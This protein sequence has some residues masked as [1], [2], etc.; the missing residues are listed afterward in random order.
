MS[1]SRDKT[2]VALYRNIHRMNRQ[3]AI[4]KTC[5]VHNL[6]DFYLVAF[7]Y[8]TDGYF[9]DVGAYDGIK[10]SNT[11]GLAKAGWSGLCV[12]PVDEQYRRCITNHARHKGVKCIKTCIGN[13]EGTIPFYVS[14]MY[15][16]YNVK[17]MD[18]RK[19]LYQDV[20]QTTS[21]IIPLD[22]ALEN[23]EVKPRFEVLSVDVEG[24]EV[25]VLKSFSIDHWQPEICIIEAHER[26]PNPDMRFNAPF[27]NEYFESAGYK[28]VYSDDTNNVYISPA[29]VRR[30]L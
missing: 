27:I 2:M 1:S 4:S 9:V 23:N 28:K 11:W 29:L 10:Y 12:E 5:Q 26:H 15:S 24:A 13:Q 17:Q 14:D 25:G 7:D 18:L 20:R 21:P 8:K 19:H 6:G 3:Y 16:T 22:K 30:I